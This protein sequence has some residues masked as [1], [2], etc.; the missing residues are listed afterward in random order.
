MFDFGTKAEVSVI[1]PCYRCVDTIERAV[2]AVAAQT[3]PPKEVILVEDRSDDGTL[4][5]V[6][7]IQSRYPGGWLRVIEQPDN[8]GPGEA[9]NAG[10]DL[11]K[12][13]YIAFLDADDTWHPQKLEL[14]FRWMREHPEVALTGHACRQFEQSERVSDA[15]RYDLSRM[16]CNLIDANRLFWRNCFPTLSVML[17]SSLPMRFASGKYYSEDYLLWLTIACS[18]ERMAR[19][20][21]PLAFM[22]KAPYGEAGLSGQLWKMHKGELDTYKRIR[23]LGCVTRIPY[24][25]LFVWSWARFLKRALITGTWT[26]PSKRTG[27]KRVGEN[28]R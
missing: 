17:R 18:G 26:R 20:E 16:K 23:K 13:P 6:Y 1:I 24:L 22:H 11:A 10:W 3:L 14:Q 28:G 15:K 9:R 7:E 12:E 25:A 5:L 21:Y 19:C 2:A 27:K 4:E 8:R